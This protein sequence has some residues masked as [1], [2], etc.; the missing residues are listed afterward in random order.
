MTKQQE[1]S[2]APA[3][4][5][6]GFVRIKRL[7]LIVALSESTIWRKVKI[8]HFP[9]PIKLSD[10]VTAWRVADVRDWIERTGGKLS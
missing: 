8:G 7:A 4:P 2:Q 6:E 3:L 10:C 5:A 1:P 9:K